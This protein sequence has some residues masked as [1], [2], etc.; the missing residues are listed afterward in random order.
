MA[1]RSG[2]EKVRLAKTPPTGFGNFCQTRLFFQRKQGVCNMVTMN[3]SLPDD[4]KS[5][6][7]EELTQGGYMTA[8]EYFRHLVREQQ[9]LRAQEKREALLL[10]GVQS[11][12]GIP[13][14][15]EFWKNLEAELP[16]ENKP[17]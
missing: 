1:Q 10:E 12:P 7:E 6:I 5:F 2:L 15:P 9:R 8:S 17:L 4:M 16:A 13:A 14:N 11:G 3:I